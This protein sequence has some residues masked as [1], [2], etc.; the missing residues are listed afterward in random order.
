M[1]IPYILL[2]LYY[3]LGF[4]IFLKIKY[5]NKKKTNIIDSI[6]INNDDDTDLINHI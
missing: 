2:I 4:C 3:S 6:R 5:D 1:F